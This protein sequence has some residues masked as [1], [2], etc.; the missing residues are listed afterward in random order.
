MSS[1]HER[2]AAR[3]EPDESGCLIFTGPPLGSRYPKL[4]VGKKLVRAHR[5]AFEQAFG[6]IPAGLE[7]HH[8]CGNRRC[9]NVAHLRA[10]T[11]A[12]HRRLHGLPDRTRAERRARVAESLT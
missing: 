3:V 12:E 9:V 8:S 7:L 6:P 2:F 4:A 5:W 10:V 11:R 1:P